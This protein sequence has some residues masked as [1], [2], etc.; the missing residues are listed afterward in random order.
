MEEETRNALLRKIHLL[1]AN[2]Y[3]ICKLLR[4]L[5]R[6]ELEWD[7]QTQNIF[8]HLFATLCAPRK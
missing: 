2:E 1:E 6:Q 7:N 5:N 8:D 3:E 4:L